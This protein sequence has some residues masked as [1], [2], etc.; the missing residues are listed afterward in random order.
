MSIRSFIR[1]AAAGTGAGFVFL[2]LLP[3]LCIKLNEYWNLFAWDNMLSNV[4]G[5][6]LIVMGVAIFLYCARLFNNKGEGTPAPIEPPKKLVYQGIYNYTRNPMYLGYFFIILGEFLFS[7][8]ILVAVY[9]I[10]IFLLING[11]LIYIEEPK[12]KEKFGIRYMEYIKKVSRWIGVRSFKSLQSLF[13]EEFLQ[14]G[15][16]KNGRGSEAGQ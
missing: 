9:F 1:A 5:S 7:G 16:K 6:F 13:E 12:L 2:I 15:G 10:F 11:Y 14:K 4:S 8:R 3:F